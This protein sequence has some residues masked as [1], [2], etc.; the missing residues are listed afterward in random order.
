MA[1]NPPSADAVRAWWVESPSAA[2]FDG[3]DGAGSESPIERTFGFTSIPRPPGRYWLRPTGPGS[4][5][6]LRAASGRG[7]DLLV[8]PLELVDRDVTD[9][10][11]TMTNK[12][13]IV[14]GRVTAPE[15]RTSGVTVILLNG[16]VPLSSV[17]VA[18]GRRPRA[19]EVNAAGSFQFDKLVAGD[20]LLAAVGDADM[21]DLSD[22]SFLARVAALATR[23]TV[24]ELDQQS[25]DV[26]V[27]RVPR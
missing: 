14:R 2:T 13:S 3:T 12:T 10:V 9:I 15:P 21:R 24:G 4:G 5:W 26:P 23:V 22:P 16:A 20:Y 19:V 18:P 1:Q 27:V 17:F 25:I 8:T 6:E 11:L 7:R